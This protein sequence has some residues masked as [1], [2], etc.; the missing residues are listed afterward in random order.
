MTQFGSTPLDA[1]SDIR[2]AFSVGLPLTNRTQVAAK[3]RSCFTLG[4]TFAHLP[5]HV[6]PSLRPQAIEGT[7]KEAM[8]VH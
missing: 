2:P 7:N 8:V 3:I 5:K 4:P 1:K 6:P